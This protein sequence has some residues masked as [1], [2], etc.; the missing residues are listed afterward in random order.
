MTASSH[1]VVAPEDWAAARAALLAEEKA[2]TAATDRIA[3]LRRR[4]PWRAVTK[5]YR[6]RRDSGPAGLADLFDGRRQL[7]VYHHMLRPADPS[8]CSGCSMVADQLPHLS[9]LHARDTTLTLVSRA[10]IA[11]ILAF[12]D[13][14]G[15]TMPWAE[16]TDS[17]NRDFGMGERG[18]GFTV[19][20]RDGGGIYHSYATTGRG[21]ESVPTVWGL[22]D[23]TP[24]G[25]Q[26]AWQDAPA[27]VPQTAP[28]AWWRLHDGYGA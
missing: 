12:R 13:R 19:F 23:L 24:M 18:P 7:I 4:M 15:W 10:P 21:N 27:W 16:T 11:E 28:Y 17:F 6:F 2:L 1:P 22:L 5:D 14:M 8:P 9:H 20:F 25:R 26:E 3:A